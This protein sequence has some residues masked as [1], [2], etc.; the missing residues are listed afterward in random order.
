LRFASP[1]TICSC[2]ALALGCAVDPNS[3]TI[4]ITPVGP[5]MTG[6]HVE[7][8]QIKN[9]TGDIVRLR[10]INRSG[11]EY[12]CVQSGG[13]FDG[14]ATS[15]SIQAMLSWKINAI[16]IPLNEA[17]WLGINGVPAAAA[18]DGYKQP[19]IDY[20]NLL[21]AYHIV[22]ILDLHWVGPG[23]SAADRLQPMPDADHA[24]AFWTDVANTFAGDDG[25]VFEI[26]NEPFPDSNRDS[27]AA[28]A[29]WRD[30]CSARQSVPSGGTAMMFQAI[31]MQALVD[32]V[33]ATGSPNL[34]LLGG[35][36]YSNALSQWLA[37]APVDPTGNLGAAWHVYNFN[38]CASSMCWD[39]TPATVI[40]SVPVVVTEFGERDCTNTF[41]EPL[42][43]W[44]DGHSTGYMAW[45]WNTWGTCMPYVSQSQQGRPWSLIL[46]YSS[47]TA[48]SDYARA[49]RDHMVYAA[50]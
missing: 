37:H 22:P 48:A 2:T 33:R 12:K 32:A 18:G 47:G 21:H 13:V 49:F 5:P 31:G 19:I 35:V 41:I 3:I 23:T 17:C 38:S 26:F 45:T 30:G 46:D 11:T 50:P 24:G 9:G 10:G 15:A 43:Q 4:P 20:V 29:C 6:L 34:I 42:M 28:W 7:G 44:L 14:P 16:R 25:V 27:D 8:A 1:A 36:Q 39:G 40:A